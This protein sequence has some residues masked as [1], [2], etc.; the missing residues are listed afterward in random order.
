MKNKMTILCLL[1]AC[2]AHAQTFNEKI[3]KELV[4]EKKSAANTLIVSNINGDIKITGYDGEKII[5]EAA[6]TINGK[7]TARMEKGK[8]EV[9][10]DVIDY[11]DTLI[12]Y[13]KDGCNGFG[14]RADN[15]NDDD[16]G[17]GKWGYN[18]NCSNNCNIEY[19]YTMHLTIK[20]PSGVNIVASTINEGDVTI[21]GMSAGVK[22][23]NVNGSIK[24]SNLKSQTVASTI[25]GDVDIEYAANPIYDCRFYSLNGD[26][27]A[28]FQKGLAA[29]MSFESFNGDF[30][31]NI[32]KVSQLP[33][34][35]EKSEEGEGIR[36]K[37]KGNHYRIGNGGSTFLDFE[38]FNGNVY[39][40]EKE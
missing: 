37:V 38:T 26:I 6:K 1:T 34:K 7:T 3:S 17:N 11:A 29:E 18:W 27:N 19:D 25:N 40:K 31:T 13:V 10:L 30:Y 8:T 36:F 14:R 32:D 23:N 33:A 28:I 15:G 2:W 22:A 24:L 16:N 4:F 35:V 12:V 21:A 5:V 20:V 39:L 9:Q